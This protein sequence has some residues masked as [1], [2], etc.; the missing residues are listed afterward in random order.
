[1]TYRSRLLFSYYSISDFG[2]V[3]KKIILS[4]RW[5]IKSRPRLPYVPMRALFKRSC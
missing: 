2:C 5:R 4:P 1:M 3:S